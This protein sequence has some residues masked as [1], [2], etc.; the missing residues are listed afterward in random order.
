MLSRIK[1]GKTLLQGKSLV[2]DWSNDHTTI[3][4]GNT[5]SLVNMQ[6]RST[7]N[8]HWQAHTQI[9]SPLFQIKNR[10]CLRHSALHADGLNIV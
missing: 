4:Y 8:A 5:N 2:A 1:P 9:V 7:R 3:L 6:V 10:F